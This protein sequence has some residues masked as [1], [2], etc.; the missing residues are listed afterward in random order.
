I[1]Y[2][3]GNYTES[4][5]LYNN[6]LT[7]LNTKDDL[8]YGEIQLGL[9]NIALKEKN[10]EASFDYLSEVENMVDASQYFRL[11]KEFYSTSMDYYEKVRSEERR[12]G[13]EYIYEMTWTK[14]K[15]K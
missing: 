6:A 7:V 2:N 3:L 12:V 1:E 8:L 13:K 14:R 9:A 10:Y 11:K 15:Y 4:K 5:K